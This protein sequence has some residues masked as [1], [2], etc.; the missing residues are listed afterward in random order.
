MSI[1]NQPPFLIQDLA[2]K[3][4]DPNGRIRLKRA[5]GSNLQFGPDRPKPLL[6]HENTDAI[7]LSPL[8]DLNG[9]SHIL[10]LDN[11]EEI[12]GV[13]DVDW[14][15]SQVIQNTGATIQTFGDAVSAVHKLGPRSGSFHHDWLTVAKPPLVWCRGGHWW[16]CDP[17]P[18]HR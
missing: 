12:A 10:V 9:I 11:G 1:G 16:I 6:V 17:C 13:I 18:N 5:T 8:I 7:A 15:K 14:L 3:F 2:F 4:D